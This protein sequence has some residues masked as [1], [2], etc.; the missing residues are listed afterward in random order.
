[1]MMMMMMMMRLCRT[2]LIELL[3]FDVSGCCTAVLSIETPR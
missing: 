1:M 3:S 2:Q